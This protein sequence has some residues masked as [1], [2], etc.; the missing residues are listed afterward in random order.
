MSGDSKAPHLGAVVFTDV[1]G[2]TEL[3]QRDVEAARAVRTRHRTVLEKHVAQHGGELIQYLGDGSLSSFPSAVKAVH[4]AVDIQLEAQADSTLP[5]R[6]G[7][8]QGEITFDAQGPYG[9][10]VNIAARIQGLGTAGSVLVSGKVYDDIKN[11]PAFSTVGLGSVDLKN[12]SRPV[13]V[14][15]VAVPGLD[16]PT[17][18]DV[19]AA[20]EAAEM[21][22]RSLVG[23]RTGPRGDGTRAGKSGRA[24]SAGLVA[25]LTVL[26]VALGMGLGRL[27]PRSGRAPVAR[28]AVTPGEGAAL[29]PNVAGVDVTISQDGSRVL[30]VGQAPGG[31]QLWER[32]I[33]SLDAVPIRGTSDA[34]DPV[35]SPD[36]G[37]IAFR[38]GNSLRTYVFGG[39]SSTTLVDASLAGGLAWGPDGL[40]YYPAGDRLYRVAPQGGDPEPVTSSTDGRHRYPTALPDGRHVMFT[41]EVPSAP[42]ESRIAVVDLRD[43]AIRD[44]GPGLMARYAQSGHLVFGTAN[45]TVRAAP[46]DL[47]RMT[48]TGPSITV[49][50]TGD[51]RDGPPTKFAISANGTMVYRTGLVNPVIM[52]FAWVARSGRATLVDPG[53][54]FNPDLDNRSWDLSPDGARLALKAVTDLGE[55][56][57]IKPLPA[58][59]MAR[60]TFAAGE[61]RMPRW[62]PDGQRV[63]FLSAQDDNLDVWSR[64]SDGTGEAELLVDLDRSVADMAWTPDGQS[65]LVRT[66]GTPGVIGG[67]DIYI[68][69]IGADS[70]PIPV[71]ASSADE[72]APA[73]SPD[74]RWLAYQS[75]E[76][77]RR[78]VFVRPF[79]NVVDGQ[80]QVSSG[81]GRAPIWSGDGKELFFVADTTGA[82]NDARRMMVAAVDPGPPFRVL[83][84]QTLFQIDDNYYLANNSTS[85]RVAGDDERFLMARFV[86]EGPRIELVFVQNFFDELREGAPD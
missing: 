24:R 47:R 44:I 2:Y 73:L 63:A 70:V 69:H 55:D 35:Y 56:I 38:V 33:Q 52:Q 4:A 13:E 22:E 29:L 6:I 51:L 39:S 80:F 82:N 26:T 34:R 85:Y 48:I 61:E 28:F 7:V 76:T 3:V 14:Y 25:A 54:T 8:H 40:L 23:R 9:D 37:A 65:M 53:W 74:G 64:R 45:G 16:V 83:P 43:G 67:R 57:W 12:V 31:T 30:Y 1:V 58:G 66:A 17:I 81:G 18:A 84:A 41:V 20:C 27:L 15:A 59:P 32:A 21:Q 19:T 50:R 78:E 42:E 75:D 36:G 60:L 62:S 72:A 77:G 49:L 71:L 79:P 86:G 5:L 10:S 68:V 11:Q 46:F